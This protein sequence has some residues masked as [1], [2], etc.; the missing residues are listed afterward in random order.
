M[1]EKQAL[2]KARYYAMEFI[3]ENRPPVHVRDQVDIGFSLENRELVLFEIRP[4]WDDPSEKFH[5]EFARAKY[6]KSRAVW[7]IYW[8]RA[9]GKWELYRPE[10][11][12][13][14]VEDIT[15]FFKIVAEDKYHAFG[16]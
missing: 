6:I 1:E 8:M 4:R 3:E 16:G 13:A 5:S 14:E 9:S 15:E 2:A 7:K 11:E 12:E 10:D